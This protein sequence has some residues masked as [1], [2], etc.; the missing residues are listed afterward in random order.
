MVGGEVYG[1]PQVVYVIVPVPVAP[2][3]TVAAPSV[4]RP[5]ARTYLLDSDPVAWPPAIPFED[6]W[7][8]W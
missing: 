7:I 3:T 2:V 4:A 5:F 8:F 6:P 1:P